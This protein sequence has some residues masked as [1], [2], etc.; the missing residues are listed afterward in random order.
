MVVLHLSLSLCNEEVS[1][2]PRATTRAAR[3]VAT[4]AWA[5]QF[6]PFTGG[7]FALEGSRLSYLWEVCNEITTLERSENHCLFSVLPPLGIGFRVRHWR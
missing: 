2:D 5:V 4:P 3:I 1:L 7:Y 6:P